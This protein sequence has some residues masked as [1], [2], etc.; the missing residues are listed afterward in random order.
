MFVQ[1]DIFRIINKTVPAGKHR[2]PSS[3]AL[4]VASAVAAEGT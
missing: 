2:M 4:I 1:P 3:C